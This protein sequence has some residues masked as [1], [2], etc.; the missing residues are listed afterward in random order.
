LEFRIKMELKNIEDFKYNWIDC[1]VS[2]E[3][4]DCHKELMLDYSNEPTKCDCGL[5]YV[6]YATIEVS[7]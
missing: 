4:Q 1:K 6:L 7:K 2:V 5:Y 3:C